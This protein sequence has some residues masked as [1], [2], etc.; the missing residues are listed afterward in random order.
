M[1]NQTVERK[2][3]H[4]PRIRPLWLAKLTEEV[5]EPDLPIIDPH[6]HLWKARPD[7]YLLEDLVADLRT[8]HNV[9][10]TVFIQCGSEY[11]P[12]G[13]EALR[14]VGETV[15]VAAAAAECESGR[16]GPLRACAGIVGHADCR[17]GDRID[18]VL[19]A[20][21][22]A[23]GGRFKGIRHS[24]TYD[25]AIQPTAPPGAPPG[26][27]RDPVFRAGFARLAQ[28]NLSFEAWLYHPQLDDLTDLLRAHPDQKVV[29]NHFGGPLGVGPYEGHR[30]EV[31]AR[32]RDSMRELAK[33][34][35]L[36]IK[37]GGLAMNVNG[38]GWHHEV[39]PPSSGEMAQA[40][41]PYVETAVALFGVN[42]CMFESNFPVDK[43]MCS[44]PVLWNAFKRI[45][46]GCSES[47]KDALF[48]HT[49]QQF[50]NLPA[51]G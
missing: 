46:A 4:H 31:F 39:L 49:A 23:G 1:S 25:A 18:A 16:Y 42:R 48:C 19:Q 2:P 41:R 11:F 10:S 29:L 50:Y 8:G 45:A 12:D 51:I 28:F 37:L 38:F 26:L 34:D 40:W 9:L 35:A 20:H 21:I 14:P 36:H 24:G 43:G 32:W 27:Y 3:Y 30:D 47:E 22:E 7:Q 5:L 15:F 13:P 44:Y 17:L 6:H 33:F